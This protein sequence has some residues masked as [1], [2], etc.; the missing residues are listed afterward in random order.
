M[1]SYLSLLRCNHDFRR[2]W[3][4]TLASYAGDWFNLLASAALIA[5][6]TDSGTA[7]SFMFLAR[8]LPLFLFTPFAGVLADR[9]DRKRILVLSDVLRATTVAAFVLVQLTQQIWLLYLLTIIQFSLSA[10]FTPT[11]SAVLPNLVAK[12]DLV[13]ANALDGFTW[14]TMLAIGA[15]LGGIVASF[16]GIT[17]AFA[18]DALTFLWSAWFISRIVG[19]TRKEAIAGD[20]GGLLQFVD[21]LRYLR[22]KPFILILALV[23]GSAA[24]AWGALSVLELA[25]AERYFPIGEK[26]AI[27]LSILYAVTGVGSGLGP[28]LMRRLV[29]DSQ[30]SALWALTVGFAMLT[31]GVFWMG[32]ARSLS[33]LAGATLV[34]TLG[35]G[36][37]WV[38]SAALLQTL[39]EDKFRGRVFSFEFAVFTLTQSI[40]TL[41]AG[42]AQDNIGLD[43]RQALLYTSGISLV[44]AILWTAFQLLFQRRLAQRALALDPTMESGG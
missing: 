41:W 4:A 5:N 37:I 17:T 29:G 36:T 7:V 21:G 38:F 11:H 33:E 6:L 18:V 42:V 16:F 25:M 2:L 32:M 30:R 9:F 24:L 27:T 13:T 14:S 35:G 10:L 40:A 31:I 20:G 1:G 15:L 22:G 39:T 34:R 43:A 12:E 44:V 8:F 3:L 26:G 23:K 19:P 28:L